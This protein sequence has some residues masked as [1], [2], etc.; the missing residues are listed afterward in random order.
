MRYILWLVFFLLVAPLS[1]SAQSFEIGTLL[2]VYRG[3]IGETVRVPVRFTNQT[4]KPLTLVIRRLSS[5][6]GG[7]QKNYFCPNND[8]LDQKIEDVIVRIEPR[9]TLNDFEIALD[10]G[11]A[12]GISSVK[13]LVFNRYNTS[14]TYEFDLNFAVDERS[15]KDDIYASRHIILHDVYPNPVVDYAYVNYVMMNDEVEAKIIIHS[16]LGNTIDEYS[17]PSEENKVKIRA[18]SMN[19]GI[20]FYT[21]YLDNEGVMTRKLIVKK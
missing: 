17:L 11:L 20:Y 13:Y 19:A 6:L 16:I 4:D 21:L 8:C 5:T 15:A 1:L 3:Y 9:G 14:E 12:N 2:E 10:A 18:E 7:T